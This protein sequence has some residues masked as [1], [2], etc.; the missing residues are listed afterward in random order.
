MPFPQIVGMKK[1]NF[2]QINSITAIN[3]LFVL[4]FFV[5]Y[6]N[7][8]ECYIVQQLCKNQAKS[9]GK[10]KAIQIGKNFNQQIAKNLIKKLLSGTHIFTAKLSEIVEKIFFLDDYPD[11][12]NFAIKF[13][14]ANNKTI[15]VNSKRLKYC[16][17]KRSKI[18]INLYLS[19]IKNYIRLF[20]T[21]TW[22]DWT[23]WIFAV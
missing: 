22:K 17:R 21:S 12:C 15:K 5:R 3:S 18:C 1:Q 8:E 14:N 13:R 2:I 7:I 23:T 9:L 19:I 10:I 16:M 20:T 11:D 6:K 4:R